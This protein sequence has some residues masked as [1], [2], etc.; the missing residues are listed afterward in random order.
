M[1]G[2]RAATARRV[3]WG[4]GLASIALMVGALVILFVDRH[5]VLPS[6]AARWS[7]TSVFDGVTNLAVPT[8]SEDPRSRRRR[9]QGQPAS[10]GT[11]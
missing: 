8:I 4:T 7:F 11:P 5:A 9:R 1:A 3:A 2:V 10:S 6:D